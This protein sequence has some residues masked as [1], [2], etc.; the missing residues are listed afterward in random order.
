MEF[1]REG[2]GLVAWK[3][4]RFG[5]FLQELIGPVNELNGRGVKFVSLRE[6]LDTTP[7]SRLVYHVFG[8][9]AEFE[10]DIVQELTMT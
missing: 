1:C 6:S 10:R 5:R 2:D 9:V 7:G 3:L 4:D 8:A